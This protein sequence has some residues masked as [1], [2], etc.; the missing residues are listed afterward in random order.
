[1]EN[2]TKSYELNSVISKNLKGTKRILVLHS[3]GLDSSVCVLLALKQGLD[4]VSLG[5]D[6]GQRSSIEMKYADR[7]CKKYQVPRRIIKVRWHK[8]KRII[9]K[10]RTIEEI[11]TSVSSAFLPGRNVVFLALAAA[12]SSGIGAQEIWIGVNSID[13]SGYSDCSADFIVAF[14]Q[15]LQKAMPGGP[16]VFAP[17]QELSKPEIAGLAIALGLSREETWSCYRPKIIGD[18]IEPCGKC[19]GCT[20]DE[21]AWTNAKVPNLSNPKH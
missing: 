11:R 5:I 18:S 21:Y 16:K 6:F 14:Q 4:V 8:P 20:L 9:P 3:G 19:D 7:L 13:Y 12:E 2:T 17:L 10:N 15:M 1:M